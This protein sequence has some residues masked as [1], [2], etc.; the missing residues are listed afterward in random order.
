MCRRYSE[1]QGFTVVAEYDDAAISGASTLRPGY[2]KLLEDARHGVFEVIV[3]EGLD[4]LSRDLAD[5][6]TLYKHLS[7]LGVR[8]WTV[9]EGEV[10]ELH[11]GLKGTMNALYLKDLA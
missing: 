3:A 7:Y 4:R 9:A 6:A 8:L 11:V 5:L 1:L 2:Q 10:T